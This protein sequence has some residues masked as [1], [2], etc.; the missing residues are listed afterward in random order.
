MMDK[1]ER[2]TVLVPSELR[3]D[4]E[5]LAESDGITLSSYV[6]IVLKRSVLRNVDL[7]IELKQLKEKLDDR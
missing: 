6:R 3:N 7:L 4:M 1:M 5:V 2:M